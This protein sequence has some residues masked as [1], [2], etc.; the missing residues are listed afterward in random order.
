MAAQTPAALAR[1]LKRGSAEL[2]IDSAARGL[3]ASADI[4]VDP[5]THRVGVPNLW[6]TSV[7]FYSL[8]LER[9]PAL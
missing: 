8:D 2:L 9:N 4:G 1:E 3:G 6:G 5:Q 7:N